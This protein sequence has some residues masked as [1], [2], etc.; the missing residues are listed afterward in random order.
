[1]SDEDDCREFEYGLLCYCEV[2]DMCDGC[3]WWF[4]KFE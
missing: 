2:Y 3:E 4:F 1:M